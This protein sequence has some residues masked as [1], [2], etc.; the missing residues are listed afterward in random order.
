MW[1][2]SGAGATDLKM[3]AAVEAQ[4]MANEGKARRRYALE[5]SGEGVYIGTRYLQRAADPRTGT[6]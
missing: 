5:G 1:S 4:A 2:L 6:S 3:K